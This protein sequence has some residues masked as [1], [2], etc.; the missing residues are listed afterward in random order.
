L[1]RSAEGFV[2]VSAFLVGRLY[3]R[4]FLEDAMGVHAKL[5]KRSLKIYGYHIVMLTLLF[6]VA[7][8]YAAHTHRAAIYNLLNFYIDHPLVA[9]VGSALLIYCP[10]LLDILPMYIIF[11][12]LTPLILS[13]AVR[14]G[15]R[16]LLLVSGAFWFWAQF[17]LRDIVHNAIVHVTHLRIPL[18][19]S[20]AFNL[21]AWQMIWIVGLWLGARSATHEATFSRIPGWVAGLSCAACLFFIGIRWGWLGP[22]LTQQALGIKL[23]K[24]HIGPLR[25]LNLVT[26]STVAYWLRNHLLRWLA[27][28]PFVTL[29]KASLRV[30]CAH[31]FFVFIGLSLLTHDVGQAVGAPAEQL[32]GFLAAALLAITFTGLFLIARHEVRERQALRNRARL[33]VLTTAKR[34][35]L[36]EET[37]AEPASDGDAIQAPQ[38][39]RAA[40]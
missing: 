17:G 3:I 10:P 9:I 25:V 5:W 21:F 8:A 37:A 1:T 39:I 14:F 13:A 15:W 23:D 24:W 31:V 16:R 2:F 33:T 30:F 11:L 12:F 22:H 38:L 7:A 34:L 40:R 28:E 18:Q 4:E 26:F 32:H 20:G 35:P 6:T 29:G 19:E 27:V 36:P